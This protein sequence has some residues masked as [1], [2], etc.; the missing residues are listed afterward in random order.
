MRVNLQINKS[1]IGPNRWISWEFG[2]NM[3]MFLI[4]QVQYSNKAVKLNKLE[5]FLVGKSTKQQQIAVILYLLDLTGYRPGSQRDNLKESGRGI[6]NLRGYHIKLL[7]E[8]RAHFVFRGKKNILYDKTHEVKKGA[9]DLLAKFLSGAGTMLPHVTK[10]REQFKRM[11]AKRLVFNETV[12]SDLKL[13][14]AKFG[15]TP[16]DFRTYKTSTTFE[17]KLDDLTD[18]WKEANPN[19]DE[20]EKLLKLKQFHTEAREV[21]RVE[22]NHKTLKAGD[23][24]IDPRIVVA[25]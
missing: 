14:L 25:W 7:G 6:S 18:K 15:I 19:A 13:T 11:N 1:L 8:N 20:N 23:S 24:Y 2:S 9:Y 3:K 4:I 10:N 17:R 22:L 12:Y 5:S 21:V 16:R